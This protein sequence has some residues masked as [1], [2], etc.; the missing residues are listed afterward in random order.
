MSHI[1]NHDKQTYRNEHRGSEQAAIERDEDRRESAG[2]IVG[3]MPE[4]VRLPNTV[5]ISAGFES[6]HQGNGTGI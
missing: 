1:E 3:D 6:H 4:E 2:E 5:R